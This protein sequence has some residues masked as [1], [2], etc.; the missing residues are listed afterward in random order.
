MRYHLDV[1]GYPVIGTA[2]L[3]VG[4]AAATVEAPARADAGSAVSIAWTG[5]ANPQDFISIDPAGA[6]PQEYGRYAYTS[7]G[8][9]LEITV[10]EAPGRYEVRYTWAPAATR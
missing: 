3:T 1:S 8:S 9:P 2:P 5:P 4:A 6:P 10:P 7:K